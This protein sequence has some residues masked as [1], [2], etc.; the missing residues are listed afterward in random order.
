MD[1][2]DDFFGGLGST[3]ITGLM[4][5]VIG[6]AIAALGYSGVGEGRTMMGQLQRMLDPDAAAAYRNAAVAFAVGLAVAVF[7]AALVVL[8][9]LGSDE[10]S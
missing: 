5:L 9:Y 4:F 1:L 8:D 2:E 7:G 6:L 10:E 3:G